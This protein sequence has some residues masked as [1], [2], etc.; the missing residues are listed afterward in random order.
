[1]NAATKVPPEP[2]FIQ[3][4][5]ELETMHRGS[6]VAEPGMELDNSYMTRWVN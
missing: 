5:Q 4:W 3:D 2:S 6:Q 1:M